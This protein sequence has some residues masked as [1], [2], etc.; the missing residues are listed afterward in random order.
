MSSLTTCPSC[1]GVIREDDERACP[2]CEQRPRISRRA[3]VGVGVLL[4]AS[5]GCDYGAPIVPD[6]GPDA[7]DGDGP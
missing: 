2:T 3:L 4:V 1:G 6:A 7:G 5:V